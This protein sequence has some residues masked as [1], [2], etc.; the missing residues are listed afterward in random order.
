MAKWGGRKPQTQ[1]G[2]GGTGATETPVAGPIARE[3]NTDVELVF[4]DEV[5][6]QA[7]T[8]FATYGTQRSGKTRFPTTM[9]GIT[10]LIPLD[11]NSVL[12]FR[13]M[14]KEL[15]EFRFLYP[16]H[17]L[18]EPGSTR[19]MTRLNRIATAAARKREKTQEEIDATEAVKLHYAGVADRIEDT[20]FTYCGKEEVDN[21]VVDTGTLVYDIY[22]LA[23]FGRLESN[24]QRNRGNLNNRMR[25]LFNGCAK[26]LVVIHQHKDEWVRKPGAKEDDD[27]TATGRLVM[28]AWPQTG[29]YVQG[30]IEHF[31]LQD[32]AELTRFRTAIAGVET[33]RYG[34]VVDYVD[35]LVGENGFPV[36]G[37]RV[38]DSQA[39]SRLTTESGLLFNEDCRFEAV[40]ELING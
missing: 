4:G 30:I 5:D 33:A 27:R 21:V 17:K 15:G 14:E 12:T 25:D 8:H 13:L 6:D 38:F 22:T 39:Q 34:S 20:F 19:E 10:G 35:A 28:D 31:K 3:I 7:Y 40:M 9:P 23:E 29:L 24:K 1:T 18:L 37:M 26:N 32:R 36:F 2:T 11:R 16:K